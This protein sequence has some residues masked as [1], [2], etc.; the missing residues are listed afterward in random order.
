[1]RMG[2]LRR[3]PLQK[4]CVELRFRRTVAARPAAIP[5]RER[6]AGSRVI[7]ANETL[8]GEAC[9]AA[10]GDMG[11]IEEELIRFGLEIERAAVDPGQIRPLRLR[12]RRI[13][14][15]L[16]DKLDQRIAVAL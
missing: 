3:S 12:D 11:I 8:P 1:M 9:A 4:I 2:N 6:V 7:H 15:L 5:V 16:L 14:K 13:G 10:E